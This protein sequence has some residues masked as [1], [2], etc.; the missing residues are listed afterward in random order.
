MKININRH[1][2]TRIDGKSRHHRDEQ[3][4]QLQAHRDLRYG[5]VY[6]DP[7]ELPEDVQKVRTAREASYDDL[8]DTWRWVVAVTVLAAAIGAVWIAMHLPGVGE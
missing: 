2:I 6:D 5:H 3:H 8:P 7:P 1:P 4:R